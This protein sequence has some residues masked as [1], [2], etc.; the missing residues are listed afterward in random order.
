MQGWFVGD[1]RRFVSRAKSGLRVWQ[2]PPRG[3]ALIDHAR[4]QVERT[5]GAQL[6]REQRIRFYL[7]SP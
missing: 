5:G 2:L 1:D 4:E 7:E 3:Q 6:T